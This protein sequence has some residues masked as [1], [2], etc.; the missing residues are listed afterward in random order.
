[1]CVIPSTVTASVS[2]KNIIVL[3]MNAHVYLVIKA[4]TVYQ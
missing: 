2:L 1:M 3:F 4:P